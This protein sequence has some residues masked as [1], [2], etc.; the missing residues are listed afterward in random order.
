MNALENRTELEKKRKEISSE[1]KQSIENN[2]AV[3]VVVQIKKRLVQIEKG[4]D[5]IVASTELINDNVDTRIS[6]LEEELLKIIEENKRLRLL[7][8]MCF[9][10]GIFAFLFVII[11]CL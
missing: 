7:K 5:A 9:S 1:P 2:K 4:M 8:E 3:E 10:L 11:R 6:N